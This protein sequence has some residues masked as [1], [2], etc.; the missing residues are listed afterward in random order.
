MQT[1]QNDKFIADVKVSERL[2]AILSA[3]SKT[4]QSVKINY[5][6]MVIKYQLK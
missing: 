1:I 5:F 4:K 2:V 3:K 6:V